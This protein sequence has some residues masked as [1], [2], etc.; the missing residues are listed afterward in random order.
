[1][2]QSARNEAVF[3]HVG[4]QSSEEEGYLRTIELFGIPGERLDN[5]QCVVSKKVLSFLDDLM[6]RRIFYR[7][8]KTTRCK[9]KS[10]KIWLYD[11]NIDKDKRGYF[12][13][14]TS[15]QDIIIPRNLTKPFSQ[16]K[17]IHI[18]SNGLNGLELKSLEEISK[19]L[20]SPL[21]DD[22]CVVLKLPGEVRSLPLISDWVRIAENFIEKSAPNELMKQ[23][24]FFDS[25][26][27]EV[28]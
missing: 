16:I 1:M 15:N 14:E 3:L 10:L 6:I 25:L 13:P 11:S 9:F 22:F 18:L 17:S 28:R 4:F 20:F 24:L 19:S 12:V 26:V 2:S 8:R 23:N 21:F 7:S 27:I 5:G